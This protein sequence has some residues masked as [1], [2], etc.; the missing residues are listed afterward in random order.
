[1]DADA[2]RL[3]AEEPLEVVEHLPGVAVASFGPLRHRLRDD[4]ADPLADFLVQLPE[5]RGG[6]V[7]MLRDQLD[8]RAAQEGRPP[9]QEAE[10]GRPQSVDVDARTDHLAPRAL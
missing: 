9:G 6:L 3:A 2:R 7:L 4:L 1:M 5:R 8:R 10:E